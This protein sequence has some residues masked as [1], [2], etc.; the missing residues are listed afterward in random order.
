MQIAKWALV[1]VVVMLTPTLYA[2]DV[3]YG[4]FLKITGIER[5]EGKIVLPT[6]RKK[7]HNVRILGKDTYQFVK[8]CT[9]PCVQSVQ[10]V[11]IVVTDVRPAKERSDMWIATVAFNQAW[12]VTFLV[13]RNGETYQIKIPVNL[14]FLQRTFKKRTEEVI[15]AAVKEL[16]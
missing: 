2:L 16:Q 3:S 14:F 13:F 4:S 10:T 8:S 5:A 15:T 7:Y 1:G 9:A 6:E 12:Q 11:E